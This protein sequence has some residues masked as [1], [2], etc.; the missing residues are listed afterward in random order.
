MFCS[1]GHS[2]DIARSGYINLLQPQDKRS[3]TPG[4]TPAAVSARRSLH[5]LGITEPLFKAISGMLGASKEDAVLD[6][7]SGEG[8]YLAS[9]AQQSGFHGYGIDI[10]IPATEAAAKRYPGCEWIVANAD[11]FIPYSDQSF[12]KVLSLTA[13][14]NPDE[15]HRVLRPDGKLLVALPAPDDLIELR[16]TGRDRSVRTMESF[17]SKFRLLDQQR[18]TTTAD[19]DEEAIHNILI[20]IYRPLQ[21]QPPKAGRITFSL[22]LLLFDSKRL[23]VLETS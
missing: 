17:A 6:I 8:F 14:M 12:S 22:D 7:G 2:F 15:F 3:K 4:D 23:N 1:Q 16:G 11:R 13:R 10:S 19:L 5:D 21:S 20:S 9:L 18:I